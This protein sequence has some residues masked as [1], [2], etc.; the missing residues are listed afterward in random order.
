MK[1]LLQF[2][3]DTLPKV[4][5]A[6]IKPEKPHPNSCCGCGCEECVWITYYKSIKEYEEKVSSDMSQNK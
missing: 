3:K 4:V 5:A 6:H 1:Q 2:T